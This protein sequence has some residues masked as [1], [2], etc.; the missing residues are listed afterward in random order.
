MRRIDW[1]TAGWVRCSFIAARE[2]LRSDATRRNTRNS[3]NS[4]LKSCA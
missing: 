1:L 2:K 3:L 4:M